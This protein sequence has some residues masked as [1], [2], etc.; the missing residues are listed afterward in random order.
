[1]QNFFIGIDGGA[2]KTRALLQNEAGVTLGE[3][4]A[5]PSNIRLSIS[6]AWHNIHLATETALH[7]AGHVLP[8]SS[9]HLALGLAG[10]DEIPAIRE[11]FLSH[12]PP[13]ASL[14]LINDAHAACI[15][16]HTGQ[17]GSVI[18]IGTGSIGFQIEHQHHSRVGGH[19]FPYSDEGSGAWMGLELVRSSFQAW[20]GLT[21]WTPLLKKIR[22]HWGETLL[23]FSS[24][25]NQAK[26]S[27]FASL[28]PFLFEAAS[29]ND[30]WAMGLIQKA[31]QALHQI[32]QGLHLKSTAPLPMCLL[33]G[34]APLI[35]PYL[36]AD[37]QASLH[38]CQYDARVGAILFLKQQQGF[39]S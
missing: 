34:L 16:A 10:S 33:G 19:G 28:A 4:L 38:P 25:A 20:D 30:A 9:I 2:T 1:M 13:Y 22:A 36:S 15:G 18:I 12:A 7:H 3:G 29:Q 35:Q 23:A 21:P 14:T 37:F 5:G 31:A 27:D 26:P 11:A 39:L 24:F 32:W 17:D 6:E 8:P